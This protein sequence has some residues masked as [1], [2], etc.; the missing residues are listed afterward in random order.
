VAE[1]NLN[2]RIVLAALITVGGLFTASNSVKYVDDLSDNEINEMIQALSNSQLQPARFVAAVTE[3]AVM[4]QA[5]DDETHDGIEQFDDGV[6]IKG[7][8]LDGLSPQQLQKI[9]L[10]IRKIKSLKLGLQS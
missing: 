10:E 1:T 6:F 4:N 7:L 2:K 8:D 9:K 3:P 5:P